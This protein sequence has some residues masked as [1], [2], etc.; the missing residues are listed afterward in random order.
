[1]NAPVTLDR[2]FVPTLPAPGIQIA[3]ATFQRIGIEAQNGIH[4]LRGGMPWPV[5][6]VPEETVSRG[7][8]GALSPSDFPPTP[9]PA[10]PPL[11]PTPAIPTAQVDLTGLKPALDIFQAYPNGAVATEQDRR[12]LLA[13]VA[14]ALGHLEGRGLLRRYSALDVILMDGEVSGPSA[15]S[16]AVMVRNLQ[17][18]VDTP[19]TRLPTVEE[20]KRYAHIA[21]TIL[22]VIGHAL[23]KWADTP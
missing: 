11:P 3:I 1:M 18:L 12:R 15:A 14:Y 22:I 19:S 13:A 4:A 16:Y 10:V 8:S 20:I 2:P 21:G 7:P 9:D 5:E 6:P 23:Q 17:Q